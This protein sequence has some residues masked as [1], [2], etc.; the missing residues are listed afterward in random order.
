MGRDEG[1]KKRGTWK[2][3]MLKVLWMTEDSKL[4]LDQQYKMEFLCPTCLVFINMSL[5]QI[6]STTFNLARE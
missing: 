3:I 4:Y 1:N 5:E 2:R 6:H